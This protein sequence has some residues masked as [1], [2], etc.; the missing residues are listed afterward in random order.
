MDQKIILSDLSDS[1]IDKDLQNDVQ[2]DI[3]EL[4]KLCLEL[5]QYVQQQD[6][7]INKIDEN[8]NGINSIILD[9]ESNINKC[10]NEIN[11]NRNK[12]LW[13]VGIG[14]VIGLLSTGSLLIA[15]MAG[16]TI[17]YLGYKL[18]N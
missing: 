5:G 13:S 10:E 9:G 3:L 14:T 6:E 16:V 18:L 15:P 17:G 11:K 8:V 12:V 4:E 1:N 7:Y 2:K